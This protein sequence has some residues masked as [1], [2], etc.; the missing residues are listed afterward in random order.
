MSK[1]TTYKVVQL[2]AE[3]K[4]FGSGC[5]CI[6]RTV[7]EIIAAHPDRSKAEDFVRALIKAKD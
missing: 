2:S 1:A 4:C 6:E 3:Q 5:Y 7:V